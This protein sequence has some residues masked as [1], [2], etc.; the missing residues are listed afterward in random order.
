MEK[1]LAAARKIA[2]A[3]IVVNLP[4]KPTL[5]RYKTDQL[6]QTFQIRTKH[7]FPADAEYDLIV[8]LGGIRPE[9]APPVL[10]TINVDGLSAHVVEVNPGRN[11]RRNFDVRLPISAGV[12]E[13][14]AHFVNDGYQPEA[15]PLPDP[16]RD[17]H[18]TIDTLDVRG[19]FTPLPQPIP[20]SHRLVMISQGRPYSARLILGNLIRRAWRRPAAPGEIERLLRLVEMAQEN[21][22]TFEQGIQLALQAVLVSPHF[23]FRIERHPDPANPTAVRPI[24]DFELATRLSYFLWASMPDDPL[25]AAAANGALRKPEVLEAQV[26]RMLRNPRSDALID[27]FAG[28]WLQLRNLE[29]H[30]PDPARFPDFDDELRQAMIQE[31]RLFFRT[32]LRE[33]RSILDLL[34]AG[35]TFLNERLARHYGLPGVQG[36]E[37]RRVNLSTDQ[38]RGILTHASVLT[39]SSYPTRTSPVIRGKWLLENILGAP[40][41][42]PPPDVPILEEAAIGTKA[43]LREQ[44]EQHRKDPTCG[45]CHNRM[46]PLGFGMENYDAIGRWRTMDGKFPIDASGTLPDG[47]KFQRPAD[48]IAI[49]STEKEAFAETVAEKMLTYALGRGLESYDKPAVQSISRRLAAGDYRFSRLVVEIARSLPFQMSRGEGPKR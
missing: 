29:S 14:H 11:Q 4:V 34:G 21:G 23:L 8:Q 6:K 16:V 12:H 35:F 49:L 48:L 27:S 44:F 47:R 45:A 7:R 18:L 42:P 36:K 30:Q 13:I 46:D 25:Y 39:V 31:T 37:F 2:G 32:L 10:L 3:A 43:S 24:S 1:Y 38:R 33:D 20:E 19:P 41:P 22:D 15:N 26:R 17:R 40:P 5:V 28:Q 9:G